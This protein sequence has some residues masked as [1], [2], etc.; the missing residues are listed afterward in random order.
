[1]NLVYM[2]NENIFCLNLGDSRSIGLKN[3]GLV[4]QLTIDH[5][6]YNIIE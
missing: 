1:M 6:P 2:D 3:N 4:N 5:K